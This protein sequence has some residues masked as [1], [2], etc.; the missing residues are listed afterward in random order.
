MK[1][2]FFSVIIPTYNQGNLLTKAVNS[3]LDQSFKNFEIIIIDNFSDDKTQK[4]V[5]NFK[6]DKIIYEKIRNHGV[7]AKSRNSGIK[8]SNGKWLAFLDSDDYWY[9][10]RL[11]VVSEFLLNNNVYDVICTDELIINE[12]LNRKKIWK[13]G[14]YVSDF[15]KH[16]LK[17][18]NCVSTSASIVKREFLSKQNI[19][20]NEQRDFITAED[21]DFFMNL[22]LKNAKFKFLHHV[23]GEHLFHNKSQSSNYEP[24]KAAVMSVVKYHVF[25]VQDF[26]KEKEEMWN[27]LKVNFYFMDLIFFLK[28]RKE[29]IKGFLTFFKMFLNFPMKS[30]NFM[31]FKMR[32]NG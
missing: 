15:Y 25:K 8:I 9:R 17:K 16:L 29:Y 24:H 31:F 26:T 27:S 10:E 6:S 21:Y 23:L 3:V 7:I 12:I 18:G 20:F 32:K 30:L 19:L 4:I 2:I 5:E 22:A 14:P 28:Y 1:S 11:Q 13:Y